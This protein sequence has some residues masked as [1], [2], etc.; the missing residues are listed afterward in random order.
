MPN[1][2]AET[3][4]PRITGGP[5]IGPNAQGVW[6]L[7]GRGSM[8]RTQPV[9]HMYISSRNQFYQKVLA[10]ENKHV[11]QW[12]TGMLSDLITVDGLWQAISGLSDATQ[13]GLNNKIINAANIWIQ[14]QGAILDQRRS[15]VETEAFSVSA[16]IPPLYLN[17]C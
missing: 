2:A 16:T 14:G 3:D 10:H 11:Q 1:P 8:A 5:T 17:G 9:V 7:T 6:V 4:A 12:Q 13:Q 15:A